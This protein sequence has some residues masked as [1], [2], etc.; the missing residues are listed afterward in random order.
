MMDYYYPEASKASKQEKALEFS[1][2]FCILTC[3]KIFFNFLH[4][5]Q[6][7]LTL[8]KLKNIFFNPEKVLQF[9][10]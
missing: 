2:I 7:K 1:P 3:I 5:K 8:K 9:S 10:Y 6:K 4:V